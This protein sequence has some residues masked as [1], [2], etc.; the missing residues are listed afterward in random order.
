ML[1][2]FRSLGREQASWSVGG[3]KSCSVI[4]SPVRFDRSPGI[5]AHFVLAR[6]H[7]FILIGIEPQLCEVEV[8]VAEQ[9]MEKTTI[10]G[11]AQTAVKES[12]DR[13][14]RA[15]IN[16]GYANPWGKMMI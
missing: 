10:V 1:R 6:F 7:S 5:G 2:L 11:L 15:I 12:V 4:P 14:N 16:S 13:V 9:G 3:R 8:D